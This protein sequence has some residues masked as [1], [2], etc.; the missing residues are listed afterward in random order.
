[1][2]KIL[3]FFIFV[4]LNTPMK[5]SNFGF[6]LSYPRRA[7]PITDAAEM[8]RSSIIIGTDLQSIADYYL[9]IGKKK[10][11]AR[12][13]RNLKNSLVRVEYLLRFLLY[14]IWVCLSTLLTWLIRQQ[15]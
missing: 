7:E 12:G 9:K 3:F 1:M 5:L 6:K 15:A 14:H 4:S 8:F 10:A 11:Y 2:I 13:A